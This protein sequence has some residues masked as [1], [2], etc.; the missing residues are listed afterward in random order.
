LDLDFED[1]ELVCDRFELVSVSF[2]LDL[3][4][5]V[6]SGS[7]SDG[8]NS[9]SAADLFF[10]VRAGTWRV[11][12]PVLGMPGVDTVDSASSATSS[13]ALG[14]ALWTRILGTVI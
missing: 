6:L 11:G 7:A 9:A 12:A 4:D 2:L 3:L 1:P 10:E 13:G 5:M 8:D 14:D